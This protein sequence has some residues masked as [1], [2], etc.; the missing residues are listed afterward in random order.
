MWGELFLFRFLN[1]K[2]QWLL[3]CEDSEGRERPGPGPP[4]DP[5]P[6]G[7]PRVPAP[8]RLSAQPPAGCCSLC[9]GCGFG[10]SDG[11]ARVGSTDVGFSAL[12]F[13]FFK[14]PICE[15]TFSPVDGHVLAAALLCFPWIFCV[16]ALAS[17]LSSFLMHVTA[18]SFLTQTLKAERPFQGDGAPAPPAPPR[19]GLARGG[20]TAV[21]VASLCFP[22]LVSP[23]LPPFGLNGFLEGTRWGLAR[24]PPAASPAQVVTGAPSVPAPGFHSPPS[25]PRWTNPALFALT[26]LP[27]CLR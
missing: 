17:Y 13:F 16:L 14:P 20:S 7:P 19:P 23:P 12:S 8:W 10:N 4:S 18:V 15:S 3:K 24:R 9:S 2:R 26:S 5:P 25:C 1:V 21:S 6:H 22:S 27:L 11:P